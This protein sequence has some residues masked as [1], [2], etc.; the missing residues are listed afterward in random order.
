MNKEIMLK[1]IKMFRILNILLSL[2]LFPYTILAQQKNVQIPIRCQILDSE[3]YWPVP[4]ATIFNTSIKRG[5]SANDEGKFSMTVGRFDTIRISSVGYQS[6]LICFKDSLLFQGETI[7]L[8]LKPDTRMLKTVEITAWNEGRYLVDPSRGAFIVANPGEKS[9]VPER[10]IASEASLQSPITYLYQRLNKREKNLVKL[11]ELK[12]QE[13]QTE[14]EEQLRLAKEKQYQEIKQKRI[15]TAL[16]QDIGVQKQEIK[17]FYDYIKG[18]TE[19]FLKVSD[20]DLYHYLKRMFIKFQLD[21]E[22]KIESTD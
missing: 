9:N 15:T 14:K 8:F 11:R 17:P 1:M 16:L 22:S 4:D 2:A 20:Y 19:F 6:L 13:L 7:L 12:R 21:Q 3:N 5:K 18:N 10:E